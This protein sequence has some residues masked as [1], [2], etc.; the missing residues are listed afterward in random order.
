[1]LLM[2]LQTEWRRQLERAE[3]MA[4]ASIAAEQSIIAEK[5]AQ[6]R[7]MTQQSQEQQV[8]TLIPVQ[9]DRDERDGFS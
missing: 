6:I 5:E 2:W 8:Q 4:R 7:T 1:M 3:E 9:F